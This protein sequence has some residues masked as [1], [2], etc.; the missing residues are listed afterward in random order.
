MESLQDFEAQSC[1][2][3]SLRIIMSSLTARIAAVSSNLGIEMVLIGANQH[4]PIKR[5]Q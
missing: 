4:L 5:Q 1:K 3:S 2:F